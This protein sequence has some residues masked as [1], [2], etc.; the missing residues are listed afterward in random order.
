MFWAFLVEMKYTYS[1]YFPNPLRIP[2]AVL[3]GQMQWIFN[4]DQKGNASDASY[5]GQVP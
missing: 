5:V 3:N 1:K 2:E 4:R